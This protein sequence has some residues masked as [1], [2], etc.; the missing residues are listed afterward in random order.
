[1]A[2][3]KRGGLG[4]GLDALFEDNSI[5]ISNENMQKMKISEIEPNKNQ[6]RR[7]FDQESLSELAESI[8]QHGVISPLIIR[9]L[10]SGNYQLV[11]GERRWRA[12]RMA[13]LSEVP[14]IVKELSD[15]E[16]TEIALI[17]NLQ[18]E[19]LNPIEEAL[20]FRRLIDEFS[21]TQEEVSKRVNKSRSAV[22]NS[23]RLLNL[24]DK[25]IR[26]IEDDILTSGHAK[27]LLSLNNPDIMIEIA[28]IAIK[29]QC[30]VREVEKLVK[31]AIENLNKKDNQEIDLLEEYYIGKDIYFK[32]LEIAM[33]EE[34][35]RK[36]NIR[37]SNGKGTITIQFYD[38]QDLTEI[39][40]RL[41]NIS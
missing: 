12:A 1:M 41:S 19:N 29:N 17:E 26:Y 39:A 25:I 11:A 31:K 4:K 18:R 27:A 13:G 28:N 37:Q 9:P 16:V 21:F 5:D 20:G 22:A 34:L 30:S 33:N 10:A 36:V 24:P 32:E 15:I 8:K 6:P 23:L 35:G 40:G 7:K 38:K 2:Q 3:K 14:V